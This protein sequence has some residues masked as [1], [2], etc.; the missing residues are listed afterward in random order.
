MTPPEHL[1][2][3]GYVVRR[4]TADDGPALAAAIERSAKHLA[5][6]WATPTGVMQLR[7]APDRWDNRLYRYGVFK[8][9]Q[10]VG[11]ASLMRVAHDA[12]EVGYWTHVD[13]GGRGIGTAAAKALVRAGFA[14]DGVERL[15]AIVLR[16]NTASVAVL[17]RCGFTTTTR[18]ERGG[19]LLLMEL[20]RPGSP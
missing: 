14:V 20:A 16:S 2:Q 5:A 4:L 7:A 19:T 18:A 15:E 17:D 3:D 10:L 9:G 12:F 1:E 6:P 13:H 11:G 8:G